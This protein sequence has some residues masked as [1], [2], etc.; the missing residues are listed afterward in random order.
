MSVS[1]LVLHMSVIRINRF[2]AQPHLAE[3]LFEFLTSILP[4][5]RGSEG[6]QSVQ[7]LRGKDDPNEFVII[8]CWDSVNAHKGAAEAI[9]PEK[10]DLVLPMMSKPPFGSYYV[11]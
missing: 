7:L 9:P 8:E 1:A 4:V 10:F 5:I 3:D 6:C 2:F 11:A